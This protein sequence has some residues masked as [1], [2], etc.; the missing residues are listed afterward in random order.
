MPRRDVVAVGASAGGVEALRSL[1]QGLPDDFSATLLVVLHLPTTAYSALPLILDRAGHLPA[2]TA[3]DGMPL[4]AG[5]VMVAPPDRHLIVR[6]GHVALGRGPKE[7]GHRPAIDP[8]FRSVA[9]WYG[10]QAVGVILSGTLDDG[11]AG[12][13]TIRER[14]GV[15]VVQAPDLALY[16]GMPAAAL[17]AVPDA[18]TASGRELADL[19]V[20]LTRE[21]VDAATVPTDWTLELETDIPHLDESALAVRDRPGRP[22]AMTCPDC[23]G[24][25]F[26]LEDGHVIRYRCRVGHAWSPQSLLLH[27]LESAEAAVWAAIRSLQEKAALHRN[28]AER[29]KPSHHSRLYHEERA[30]EADVSA[31]VLRDL[32]RRPLGS[33]GADVPADGEDAS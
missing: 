22:A 7:N 19:L 23:N 2:M 9:R 13:V 18:M 26:E 25:M 3:E 33:P 27:Q 14:G 12:L 31:E 11:A 21:E 16:S 6:D 1:V 28:L 29:A 10:S 8:L 15:A 32:L 5:T 24:A 20:T 17:R 4:K 30:E